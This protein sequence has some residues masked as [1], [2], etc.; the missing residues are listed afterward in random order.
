MENP[1]LVGVYN[2]LKRDR[3]VNPTYG[4]GPGGS[5]EAHEPIYEEIIEP[6]LVGEY[7][8][9]QRDRDVDPTYGDGSKGSLYDPIYET[10]IEH[11]PQAKGAKVEATGNIYNTIPE[12]NSKTNGMPKK[13]VNKRTAPAANPSNNLTFFQ[14]NGK[15]LTDWEMAMMDREDEQA[16][17]MDK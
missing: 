1:N 16:A 13:R 6:N 2:T 17:L 9:L 10:I 4:D 7:N 5:L 15:E 14:S 11:N 3:G 12:W 8:T